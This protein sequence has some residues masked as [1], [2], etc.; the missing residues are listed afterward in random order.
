MWQT[1]SR[2]CSWLVMYLLPEVLLL[3]LWMKC[4][5]VRTVFVSVNKL[6][7]KMKNE[8][9]LEKFIWLGA[10]EMWKWSAFK[11]NQSLKYIFY[12]IVVGAGADT[13]AAEKYKDLKG[14]TL[15]KLEVVKPSHKKIL[16]KTFLFCFFKKESM[17]IQWKKPETMLKQCLKW[18]VIIII[19]NF[20][21]TI[22]INGLLFAGLFIHSF[23][24]NSQDLEWFQKCSF[25]ITWNEIKYNGDF[26]GVNNLY[27]SY[28][29]IN[30][31]LREVQQNT[32]PTWAELTD[33][34]FNFG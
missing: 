28:H 14:K 3:L 23:V 21:W 25:L 9:I 22:Q 30:D 7:L 19:I 27:C 31:R 10:L 34:A 11:S 18:M 6:R 17:T 29:R 5:V 24:F 15:N 20:I 2:A 1:W 33:S 13:N 32:E 26:G 16:K 8:I 4:V 12:F